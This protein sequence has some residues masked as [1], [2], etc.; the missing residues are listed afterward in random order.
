MKIEVLDKKTEFDGSTVLLCKATILEYI[1]SLKDDYDDYEIQ[2]GIVNN[3]YLDKLI[4]TILSNGH[5]P[6]ITLVLNDL[7]YSNEDT[8]VIKDFDILDGLQRTF[9][10]KI[11]YDSYILFKEFY[12]NNSSAFE[13]KYKFSKQYSNIVNERDCSI[14]IIFKM[15]DYLKLK[16]IDDLDKCFSENFQWYEI[17][18]NLT[19]I[20]KVNKMLI[21]NAGHKSVSLK[22]QLELLFINLLPDLKKINPSLNIIRSKDPSIKNRNI[23][24]Y[25]FST[26]ISSLLSLRDGKIVAPNQ[27]VILSL[28]ENEN[29]KI[30]DVF[31]FELLKQYIEL[32][33][34]LDNAIY[35]EYKDIGINWFGRETV[36]TGIFAALGKYSIL[37]RI[38]I[39]NTFSIFKNKVLG[40]IACLDLA[41]YEK[42]RNSLEISKVNAG[43]F[44]RNLT[45]DGIIY[46]M[47]N[48][49]SKYIK[50]GLIDSSPDISND[51]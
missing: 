15:Y 5:I 49:D 41:K 18:L 36:Q 43:N 16:T 4:D 23:F 30:D 34:L 46:I 28:M 51:N 17:W 2:R 6:V 14:S 33:M 20:Q 32:I 21:L 38:S 3:L 42:I 48:L 50:W 35:Q 29:N 24:S 19:P 25:D 13:T 37:N 11:I 10:L 27:K 8:I 22:H 45:Y 39:E 1:K 44:Q 9:R 26:L 31:N 7:N 12:N 40:D 47:N